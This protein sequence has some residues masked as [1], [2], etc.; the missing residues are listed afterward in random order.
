MFTWSTP[1][2]KRLATGTPFGAEVHAL[3]AA[4]RQ[5]QAEETW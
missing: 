3:D 2:V 4:N 5:S 1:A